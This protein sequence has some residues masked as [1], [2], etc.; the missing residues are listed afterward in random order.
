MIKPHQNI[1]NLFQKMSN[2]HTIT[3]SS[4][5]GKLV[6]KSCRPEIQNNSFSRPTCRVKLWNKIP[7]YITDLPK[8]NFEASSSQIA[9]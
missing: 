7:H 5:S 6:V 9:I 8:K 2:I 1:L 4:T 3:R